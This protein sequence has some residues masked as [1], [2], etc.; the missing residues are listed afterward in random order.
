MPST[1]TGD[2]EGSLL[3]HPLIST[4]LEI[5][6]WRFSIALVLVLIHATLPSAIVFLIQGILDNAL[7]NKD[8]EKLFWLPL[9]LIGIYVLNGLVAYSRG[10]ITRGMAWGSG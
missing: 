3:Q 10:M 5:S 1:S 4:V 8:A 9:A 7:I 6:K 2:L